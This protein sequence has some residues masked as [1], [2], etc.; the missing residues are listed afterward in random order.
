MHSSLHSSGPSRKRCRSPVDSIPSSTPVMGSL[1]PTRV[2]L[3]PPRKRFRD[4]Y[5]SE[6]SIEEDT[7]DDPMKAEVDLEL[8]TSDKDDV[9]D[10]VESDPRDVRDDIKEQEAD[11]S[12]GGT[13]EV[14]IDPRSVPVIVE[15]SEEPVGEDSSSF[16]GTRDGIVR[17]FKEIPIDL[18]DAVRDFYHHMYEVLIDRIVKIE[19]V[20]GRLEADQLAASGDRARMAERIYSL[21]LENLKVH[22][23]LDIERDRIESI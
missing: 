19:T 17:S 8:G 20:Q 1:A 3:L 21:R 2:D 22:A 4:S 23:M 9:R 18:D 5:S 7:E 13:I 12:V 11:A 14:A 6:A 10:Q 16:S 15:E